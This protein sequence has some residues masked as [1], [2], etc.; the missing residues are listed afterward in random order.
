MILEYI[1][2]ETLRDHIARTTLDLRLNLEIAVALA[3]ILRGIHQQ[4]VIHLDLNS[5]IILI[6]KEQGAVYLIDLGSAAHI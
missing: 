4:N 3:R 2:G 1:V 5:K 6:G